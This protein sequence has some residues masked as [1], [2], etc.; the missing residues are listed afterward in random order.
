M[1][2]RDT[3]TRGGSF[4]KRRGESCPLIWGRGGQ[5]TSGTI[6]SPQPLT[7]SRGAGQLSLGPAHHNG[8]KETK[9][10]KVGTTEAD[11]DSKA[12]RTSLE[13][14]SPPGTHS[15]FPVPHFF[16]LRSL[17]TEPSITAPKKAPQS[18]CP[19]LGH[20]LPSLKVV[21]KLWVFI[22]LRRLRQGPDMHPSVPNPPAFKRGGFSLGQLWPLLRA[23]QGR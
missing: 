18:P 20:L 19:T 11:G 14:S 17:L 8:L 4:R 23:S 13:P 3:Q 1:F 22:L 5:G 7:H 16:S 6:C 12:R 21:P 15:T 2:L 10:W 9:L